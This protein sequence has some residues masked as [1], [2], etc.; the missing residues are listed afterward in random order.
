VFF[1]LDMLAA[2]APEKI[3]LWVKERRLKQGLR[4]YAGGPTLEAVGTWM[5]RSQDVSGWECAAETGIP[6][7]PSRREP[8]GPA[9]A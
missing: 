5:F 6:R 4:L 3:P 1:H 9:S 2:D 7:C 8:E